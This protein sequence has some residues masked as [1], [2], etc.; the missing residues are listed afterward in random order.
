MKYQQNDFNDELRSK[1]TDM[2]LKLQK[3]SEQLKSHYEPLFAE[4]SL[5]FDAVFDREGSNPF[6]PGYSSSIT[7]GMFSKETELIHIVWIW[8]CERFLWGQLISRTFP[9][10]KVSG[11]LLDESYEDI[12]E[13]LHEVTE[14]YFYDEYT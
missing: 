7:L 1:I 12:L 3:H 14:E 10:S 9:G 4:K 11:E 8:Q 13:E 2:E 5:E 6:E